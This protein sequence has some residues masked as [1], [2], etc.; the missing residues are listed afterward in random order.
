MVE[1]DKV[2]SLSSQC[3]KMHSHLKSCRHMLYENADPYIL[4]EPGGYMDELPNYYNIDKKRFGL[5]AQLE[6]I[7][8][9]ELN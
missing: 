1:F 5:R 9:T 3:L 6:F 8:I 2:D 7:K 4:Y